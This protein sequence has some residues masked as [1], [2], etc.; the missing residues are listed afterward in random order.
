VP[1]VGWTKLGNK[2]IDAYIWMTSEW[3]PLM[4]RDIV[5]MVFIREKRGAPVLAMEGTPTE[6]YLGLPAPSP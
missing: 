2:I 1:K 5:S 3:N 4:R 6:G